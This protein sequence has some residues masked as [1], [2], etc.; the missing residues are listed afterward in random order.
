MIEIFVND[1]KV[2]IESS[3]TV[4]ELINRLGYEGKKFVIAHN[5]EFLPQI[6]YEKCKLKD[7]D[8]VEILEPMSGG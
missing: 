3:L 5:L 2:E 6:A 4:K 7:G 8:K 1:K